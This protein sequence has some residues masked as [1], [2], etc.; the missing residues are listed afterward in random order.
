MKTIL[1]ICFLATFIGLVLI[2]CTDKSI[3]PIETAGVNDNPVILQKGSSES[4]AWIM[5]YERNTAAWYYDQESGLVLVIGLTDPWLRCSQGGQ[6]ETFEY[7]LIF[8]PNAD[9]DLRRLIYKREAEEL[10]AYIWKPVPWPESFS[11]FCNFLAVAG[12]PYAIGTVKYLNID[13]DYYAYD[14]DNPNANSF[15]E[16]INGTLYGADGQK[17]KLN[18]VYRGVW[19]G[20]NLDTYK[21]VFK[22]QLTPTGK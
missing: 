14:Q 22:V 16:K 11:T 19:D 10:T 7:K 6:L 4:G 12:E 3:T 20:E 18:M 21:E 1:S 9:P 2:G 17:Y 15:G 8:L 5:R 13:N